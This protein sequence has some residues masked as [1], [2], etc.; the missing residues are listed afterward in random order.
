M[1]LLAIDQEVFLGAARV[2]AAF[3]VLLASC[4]A[5]Q[6]ACQ[7]RCCAPTPDPGARSA[8]W[9]RAPSPQSPALPSR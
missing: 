6:G 8:G 7:L 5:Y 4:L 2:T 1:A 9:S 3:A